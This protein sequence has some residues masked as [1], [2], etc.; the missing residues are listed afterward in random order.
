MLAASA[1]KVSARQ[2]IH[3]A[4]TMATVATE[5]SNAVDQGENQRRLTVPKL[6]AGEEIVPTT[7]TGALGKLCGVGGE[8]SEVG[9]SREAHGD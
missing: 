2:C 6:M 4:T 3:T 8:S 7:G 1:Q 9:E 5:L